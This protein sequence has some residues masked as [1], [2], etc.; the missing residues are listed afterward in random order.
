MLA[1]FPPSVLRFSLM[2][3][4]VRTSGF[5]RLE[6]LKLTDW[7]LLAEAAVGVVV[8]PCLPAE[9]GGGLSGAEIRLASRLLNELRREA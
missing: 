5:R 8:V 7:R 3:A 6:G 2:P 4:E 1:K 9:F